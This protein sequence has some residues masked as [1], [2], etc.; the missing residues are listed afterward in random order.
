[1]TEDLLMKILAI[2]IK[3]AFEVKSDEDIL[4]EIKEGVKADIFRDPED[5]ADPE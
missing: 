2:K 1:M 3:Y 4:K 5:E